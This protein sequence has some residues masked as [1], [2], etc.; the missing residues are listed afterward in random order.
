MPRIHYFSLLSAI[1]LFWLATPPLQAV[2]VAGLHEGEA[3]VADESAEQRDKALG[4]AF[5]QVMVKLTGDPKLLERPE[6]KQATA[7]AGQ[8]VR[9]FRY[10][11]DGTGAAAA[12]R[13][14]FQFDGAALSGWLRQAGL[15][16]WGQ[17][18]TQPLVW[19]VQEEAKQRWVIAP[20]D[21]NSPY[22]ALKEGAS[23]RGLPVLTPLMDL[24][25]RS[26]GL[27]EKLWS[28]SAVEV[29]SLSQRYQPDVVLV[30]RFTF[31]AEDRWEARWTLYRNGKGEDWS[32]YAKTPAE[33]A[34]NGVDKVAGMLA[35]GQAKVTQHVPPEQLVIRVQ[36]VTGPAGQA[37]VSEHLRQLPP[38][39][40]SKPLETGIDFLT[41]RLSVR[42]GK[43][44]LEQAIAAGALL[45]PVTPPA[46]PPA[47]EPPPEEKPKEK[48]VPA[49]AGATNPLDLFDLPRAAKQPPKT[50][51]PPAG[52]SLTPLAAEPPPPADLFYAVVKAE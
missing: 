29:V 44:A 49:E 34:R 30:G 19:L 37:R 46:P 48:P 45:R 26:N 8:Y 39:E 47:K 17:D 27:T 25:E 14:R 10:L 28:G 43:A 5:R 42:G 6:V 36:G 3:V 7:L 32:D 33:A 52:A 9:Q 21:P 11:T 35:S 16:E 41:L 24:Q 12:R 22:H 51:G 23:V 50:P 2:P 18:R 13:I 40:E 4:E 31:L 15:P 1:C 20:E 38:V